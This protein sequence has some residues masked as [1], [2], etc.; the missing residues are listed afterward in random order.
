MI[1]NGQFGRKTGGGFFRMTKNED[2][3]RNKRNL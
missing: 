2:G 1:T 3:S